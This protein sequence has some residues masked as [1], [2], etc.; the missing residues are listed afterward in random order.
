[1]HMTGYGLSYTSFTYT[2]LTVSSTTIDGC[3]PLIVNVT[4][5]NTGPLSGDEV[6]QVYVQHHS[7]FAAPQ[8]RLAGFERVHLIPG[9]IAEVAITI[10]PAYHMVR[11]FHFLTLTHSLINTHSSV[12]TAELR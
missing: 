6:V 1:M 9:Q 3:D 2:G 7:S 8:I 11:E 4:L 12:H 10:M 5:I